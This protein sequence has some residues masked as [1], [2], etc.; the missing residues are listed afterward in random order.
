MSVNVIFQRSAHRCRADIHF[1][2]GIVFISGL[3]INYNNINKHRLLNEK[4]CC[5][6]G[7]GPGAQL[8]TVFFN[9]I[10]FS[11]GNYNH[12]ITPFLIGTFFLSLS[13]YVSNDLRPDNSLLELF[14]SLVISFPQHLPTQQQHSIPFITKLRCG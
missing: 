1:L 14:Y 4:K 2:K 5:Y 13:I 10:S 9:C 6:Q 7:N 8:H 12:Y 11:F 3:I